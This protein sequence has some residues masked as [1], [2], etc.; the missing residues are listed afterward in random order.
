MSMPMVVADYLHGYN[1]FP[2]PSYED[3]KHFMEH[4][5][6]GNSDIEAHLDI[7]PIPSDAHDE[8]RLYQSS[9][10]PPHNRDLVELLYP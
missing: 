9:P 8:D 1:P 6:D 2:I 5:S 7:K 3:V 4:S 10:S